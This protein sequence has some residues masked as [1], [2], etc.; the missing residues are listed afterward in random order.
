MSVSYVS[1]TKECHETFACFS[2]FNHHGMLRYLKT[3]SRLR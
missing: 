3:Y 1:G 2:E